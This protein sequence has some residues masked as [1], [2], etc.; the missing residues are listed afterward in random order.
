MLAL[1]SNK[2]YNQI[3]K[4][5]AANLGPLIEATSFLDKAPPKVNKKK[6]FKLDGKEFIFHPN[7]KNMTAGEMISVEQLIMDAQHKGENSTPGILAV[8]IRPTKI[9]PDGDGTKTTIEEFDAET[10]ESRKNFFLEHLTVDRF[11]HELAFFLNNAKSSEINSLLSTDASPVKKKKN[12]K[13]TKKE[14]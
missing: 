13:S 2:T 7:F 1:L 4:I 5:E 9:I 8:L 3:L 14:K 10:F 6:P 12:Q 11:Y